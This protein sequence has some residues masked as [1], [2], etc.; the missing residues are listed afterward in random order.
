MY[1]INSSIPETEYGPSS[2]QTH[3]STLE[4]LFWVYWYCIVVFYFSTSN[5][6]TSFEKQRLC[7][8][9][10]NPISVASE[11][12]ICVIQSFYCFLCTWISFPSLYLENNWLISFF[13][14][15]SAKS[16]LCLK[17][18]SRPLGKSNWKVFGSVFITNMLSPIIIMTWLNCFK[19][20]WWFYCVD[21]KYIVCA[22]FFLF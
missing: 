22:W 4:L 2:N 17:L 5:R 3:H 12:Q 13:V 15:C 19:V 6:Y 20:F 11:R 18:M 1:S 16:S 8:N 21:T 14:E 9:F 10:L 7:S